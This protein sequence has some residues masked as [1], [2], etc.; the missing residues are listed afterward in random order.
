M[1]QWFGNWFGT[2]GSGCDYPPTADVLAGVTYGFGAYVGTL[3]PN[4]V[5]PAEGTD[6]PLTHSP[7]DVTAQLLIDNGWAADPNAVDSQFHLPT[8]A[9][10]VW[11]DREPDE[12][13]N[14]LFAVDEQ[15]VDEGREMIGGAV[16]RHYGVRLQV[17]SQDQP[18]GWKKV[19]ELMTQLSQQVFAQLVQ[20]PDTT[21]TPAV[22]KHYQVH[23][24]S[25]FLPL[26]L[27]EQQTGS[28]RRTFH[29]LT[30][31]VSLRALD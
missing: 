14:A 5:L 31:L 17:R 23:C 11:T 27:G 10:P 1:G 12:P 22:V 15:A 19:H 8:G 18:V 4:K 13:D 21:V 6:L 30:M 24:F 2:V 25:K 9:W 16:L 29:T 20:L 3:W 28:A 26:Y 7:A